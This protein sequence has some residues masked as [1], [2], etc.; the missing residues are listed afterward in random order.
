M[1]YMWKN[2]LSYETVL[3][4]V[5]SWVV[6]SSAVGEEVGWAKPT[7][8]HELLIVVSPGASFG[9]CLSIGLQVILHVN[10]AKLN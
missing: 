4:H 1:F 8:P 10:S 5:Y 3:F 2:S 6:S 9:L 7:V